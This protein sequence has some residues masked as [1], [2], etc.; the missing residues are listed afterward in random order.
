MRTFLRSFSAL[1]LLAIGPVLAACSSE[2]LHPE[3]VTI[4]PKSLQ[5]EWRMEE[6]PVTFPLGSDRPGA[7]ELAQLDDFLATHAD[8]P[9]A[10]V[11]IDTDPATAGRELASRRY[12]ALDRHVALQGFRAEPAGGTGHNPP[13][14]PR[15]ATVY[16]GSYVAVTP[17]CPD[18]RKPS[19]ADY[20]NTQSSNFGCATMVN[21]SQMLADP[22]ELVRGRRMGPADGARAAIAIRDYREGKKPANEGQGAISTTGGQ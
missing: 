2:P 5:V 15:L 20:T 6:H 13:T 22:G 19:A 12:A 16:V 1:A 8:N 7:V 14:D 4:E 18:W 11:F 10:R 17:V 3:A 21:F 9:S